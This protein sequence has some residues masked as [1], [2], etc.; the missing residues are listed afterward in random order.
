M[1]KH[2]HNELRSLP[3]IALREDASGYTQLVLVTAETEIVLAERMLYGAA[4]VK[5]AELLRTGMFS[6]IQDECPT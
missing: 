1:N 2:L 6:C 4:G 3:V 5:A